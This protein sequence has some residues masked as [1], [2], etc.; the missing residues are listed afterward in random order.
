MLLNSPYTIVKCIEYPGVYRLELKTRLMEK[1]YCVYTI[2]RKK[3]VRLFPLSAEEEMY[4]S[5]R[6][7]RPM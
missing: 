5:F 6:R 3:L 1:L 4:N 7:R 2:M